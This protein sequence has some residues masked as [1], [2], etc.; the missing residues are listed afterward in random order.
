MWSQSLSSPPFHE[1]RAWDRLKAIV[2]RS[3]TLATRCI[4]LEAVAVCAGILEHV[5]N[6]CTPDVLPS[7][8]LT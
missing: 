1:E 8:V 6:T 2:M 5:L 7:I 4:T 3:V